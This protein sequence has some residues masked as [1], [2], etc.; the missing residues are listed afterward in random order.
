LTVLALVACVAAW[1]GSAV[2]QQDVDKLKQQLAE[3]SVIEPHTPHH[4]QLWKTVG[5]WSAL[6]R[7]FESPDAVPVE[8]EGWATTKQVLDGRFVMTEFS[9]V[10]PPK[11]KFKGVG[12]DGYDESIGKHVGVWMDSMSTMMITSEGTCSEKG[13]V[14]TSFSEYKDPETGKMKKSKAVTN[15]QSRSQYTYINYDQ[16]EKGEWVKT[17]EILFTRRMEPMR[18]EAR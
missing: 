1:G 12:I 18:K 2:A 4:A 3:A 13:N 10:I 11:M 9:G 17:M 16:N 15:L 14:I 7:M 5:R 6:V 8:S